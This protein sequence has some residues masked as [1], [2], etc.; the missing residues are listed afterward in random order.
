LLQPVEKNPSRP[1]ETYDRYLKLMEVAVDVAWRLRKAYRR[2]GLTT[3]NSGL[4]HPWRRKFA[5]ER[6]ELP[7][8]DVALAGG[9][10]DRNTFLVCYQ[11]PDP[12]TLTRVV[13]HAP[14]LRDNGLEATEV[15]PVVTPRRNTKNAGSKPASTGTTV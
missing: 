3:L 10:R 6:K 1:V 5:T 12:E 11:Q 9:W 7:L 2:A 14:K 15:T 8:K 4:W 13:L